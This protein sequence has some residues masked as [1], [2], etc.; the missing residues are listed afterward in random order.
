MVAN[1]VEPM[2][3]I[4]WAGIL[5]GMHIV[6]DADSSLRWQR[7]KKVSAS[8]ADDYIVVALLSPR[9]AQVS[10]IAVKLLPNSR[11]LG[12]KVHR[13]CSYRGRE[14]RREFPRVPVKGERAGVIAKNGDCGSSNLAL[15]RLACLSLHISQ[16]L[17]P[18]PAVAALERR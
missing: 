4:L 12:V 14:V 9:Q 16:R 17:V 7:P 2:V 15:S 8:L 18:I 13:L 11:L 3:K 6:T 1:I 10:P 5:E